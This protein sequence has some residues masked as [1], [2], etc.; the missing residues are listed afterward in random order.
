MCSSW[1]PAYEPNTSISK[2]LGWFHSAQQQQLCLDQLFLTDVVCVAQGLLFLTLASS[3][4]APCCFFHPAIHPS[5][6]CCTAAA[7]AASLLFNPHL[8]RTLLGGKPVVF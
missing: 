7:A 1:Q 4:T 6:P 3:C 5:L 8:L 2:R